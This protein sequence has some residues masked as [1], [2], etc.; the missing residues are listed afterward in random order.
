M[1]FSVIVPIYNTEKYL[2]HCLDSL[3]NQT[4]TDREIIL[5][6]DGS[7]DSS[8]H[9]CDEYARKHSDV[10][11]VHQ[12]N[13]G[14]SGAR[15]TGLKHARGEWLTFVDADDWVDTNML[16]LFQCYILATNADIYQC[17]YIETNEQGTMEAPRKTV[18]EDTVFNFHD[19]RERFLF[20]FNS[21]AHVATVWKR[22][23]RHS[24]IQEH[25]LTFVDTR[26]VYA[27][28]RLFNIQFMLHIH[29]LMCLKAAPYHYR[30]RM[31]SLVRTTPSELKLE[32]A[33]NLVEHA[34][35]TVV[36]EGLTLFQ[37]DFYKI[38]FIII[39][40]FVVRRVQNMDPPQIREII[41][42]ACQSP[43]HRQCVETIRRKW[44]VLKD[45][46]TY[47]CEW[48]DENFGLK[49][50][51]QAAWRSW[52][53]REN[54]KYEQRNEMLMER[55]YYIDEAQKAAYLVIQ[56]AGCS[57]MRVSIS[58]RDDIPDDYS[59]HKIRIDQR[60][61]EPVR[62]KDW[63]LFSFVRNP[64]ARLVSCYVSKYHADKTRNS[65]A[66]MRGFLDLDNYLGGYMKQ[67][68]GFAHFIDQ[69]VSIPHR[70]A[71]HHFRS[72]YIVLIDED[73]KPLVDYIGH[74]ETLEQDYEPIR[75]K[76]GFSPL[77]H[78]NKTEYGD[79]RDYYTTALAKKVYRKFKK[80]V[81]YFG[82]EQ[83]YR[84]LLAYCTRKG[85]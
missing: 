33:F 5:I 20:Y 75:K 63:F 48:Y 27:E 70:L 69:V 4:V 9:I 72:Q 7:T 21:I 31:D 66:V 82:Y 56:K 50:K 81:Q 29:K 26:E 77:K 55:V 59:I 65:V 47:G 34:Y 45:I 80:D 19:E 62:D 83:D 79:W 37:K 36:D 41:D 1:F 84:D 12:E 40:L 46:R 6:D 76:Y 22:V 15:N 64:F 42:R 16:E 38:Y 11:V 51:S 23:Y 60:Q 53:H 58:R 17:N 44:R 3:V 13:Q 73:G 2:R 14:L 28:D 43:F 54:K 74:F 32:R 24:I 35:Q 10:I 71:N 78:Y 30:V 68:K 25:G 57:S 8:G 61:Q 67:D 52:M 85:C 49:E 18:D 39:N